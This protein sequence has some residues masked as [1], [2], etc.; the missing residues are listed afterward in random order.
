MTGTTEPRARP[1]SVV[2]ELVPAV[3]SGD[4]TVTRRLVTAPTRNHLLPGEKE[5]SP[6][7]GGD[8]LWYWKSGKAGVVHKAVG[9]RCPFGMVGDRL[10][11]RERARVIDYRA[12]RSR[13]E[14]RVRLVYEADET[15][16]A[17]LPYPSRLALPR[18]NH[19]IANGVHREGSRFVD[20][21]LSIAPQRIQDVTDEDARREGVKPRGSG[22]HAYYAA[23][24]ILF[25]ELYGHAAWDN[26]V[27]VWR[28]EWRHPRFT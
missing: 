9:Q 11:L 27:W 26:N 24:R 23:F 28:I 15:R 3:L 1:L 6:F 13:Q 2:Q 25:C 10:W 8:G 22:S 19:C 14:A 16:S 21:V 17:W 5:H 20:T 7:L 4:K 12:A 18:L